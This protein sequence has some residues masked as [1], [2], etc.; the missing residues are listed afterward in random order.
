MNIAFIGGGSLRVLPVV[1][2]LLSKGYISDGGSI[3][4]I[5]LN[6]GRAEAVGR[7]IMRCPEFH[8][9]GCSV[10]WTDRAEEGLNGV[11][12][13]YVTMAIQRQPSLTQ[14]QRLGLEYGVWTS[15]MLSVNGAFLS[16]RGGGS[17]LHFAKVM[18]KCAPN[19]VMLIFANPVSVFSAMVNNFTKIRALGICQGFHNHKWDIPRLTGKNMHDDDI[20]AVSSGINHF[21]FIQ[22]GTWGGRDLFEVMDEYIP[23]NAPAYIESHQQ[24]YGIAYKP[25]NLRRGLKIMAQTYKRNHSLLFSSEGDGLYNLAPEVS[26]KMFQDEWYPGLTVAEATAKM[27][28]DMDE[29]FDKFAGIAKGSDDSIWESGD[30]MFSRDE[31]D[32]SN[33]IF[34]AMA[35][36][37]SF[38]IAA[39]AP[40]RG[41]VKGFADDMA[42][43]Y[44]MDIT[45]DGITAIKGQEVPNPYFGLLSAYSKHQTL[46]AQA[47]GTGDPE[48]FR[49]ALDSYPNL[50][51]HPRRS[52]YLSRMFDIY[53]DLP[54]KFLSV[55]KYF[56]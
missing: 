11:D 26:M 10:S 37:K 18:E 53:L 22:R 43:E 35:G 2:S 44:T 20:H 6:L 24:E 34:G 36:G 23:Q 16:M 50:L 46:L 1:R 56:N 39:S 52:E 31:H 14:A 5:D 42:L 47:L 4:L 25:E 38:R 49:D 29:R 12:A 51:F 48:C 9:S 30:T 33:D 41:A 27:N 8:G 28:K 15:D 21:A 19:A 54:E 32:I 40:N 7:M 55:K 3:R 13:L 45:K 17:I